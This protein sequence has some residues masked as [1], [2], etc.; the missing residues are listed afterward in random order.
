MALNP[1]RTQRVREFT[2]QILHA[3][4]DEI[5]GTGFLVSLDGRL[6]TCRHVVRDAVPGPVAV[7]TEVGVYIPKN[8]EPPLRA[9]VVGIFDESDDDIALLQLNKPRPSLTDRQVAVLG[10]PAVEEVNPFISY[11]FRRLGKYQGGRAWGKIIGD[12]DPPVDGTFLRDPIELNSEHVNYGMSGA[13]VLDTKLNLV[14]GVISEIW[15]PGASQRDRD[16][17]WAVDARVLSLEPLGLSLRAEPLPKEAS[18][19]PRAKPAGRK[20]QE[21]AA[22]FWKGAPA[23]IAEWAGRRDLL[24]RLDHDWASPDVRC[25]ALVGFGGEGKSALARQWINRLL[26]NGGVEKPDGIFWWSFSSDG[27]VDDFLEALLTHIS[28]G[29]VDAKVVTSADARAQFIGATLANGRYL[30]VL[31]GL[32][33]VQHVTG[34]SYGLVKPPALAELLS[35]LA[36]NRHDSFCLITTRVEL[37][38]IVEFTTYRCYDVNPLSEDDA[39][40]LLRLNGVAADA[41]AMRQMVKSLGGHALSLTLATTSLR[42]LDASGMDQVPSLV[43][44]DEL[45]EA[46]LEQYDKYIT[47]AERFALEALSAFRLPVA[48]EAVD[49]VLFRDWPDS[50]LADLTVG[51]RDTPLTLLARLQSYRLVTPDQASSSWTIHPLLQAHYGELMRAKPRNVKVETNYRIASF[52]LSDYLGRELIIE[53]IQDVVRLMDEK[54]DDVRLTETL[55]DLR[56]LVEA[57]YH[58]SRAEM[59]DLVWMLFRGVI[60]RGSLQYLWTRLGAYETSCSILSHLFPDGDTA[61]DPLVSEEI[62][63]TV[64]NAMAISLEHVGQLMDALPLYDRSLKRCLDEEDWGGAAITSGNLSAVYRDIG[65]LDDALDAAEKGIGFASKAGEDEFYLEARR[66][67]AVILMDLGR[68]DDAAEDYSAISVGYER[69][70]EQIS[71]ISA[72]Y[73]EFLWRERNPTARE[74]TEAVVAAYLDL[75]RRQDASDALLLLAEM[76][77]ADDKRDDASEQMARSLSIADSIGSA[78]QIAHVLAANGRWSVE[79]GNAED[80]TRYLEAAL[81]RARTASLVLIEIET[82][83]GFAWLRILEEDL[84]GAKSYARIAAQRSEATGYQWGKEEAERLEGA[85]RRIRKR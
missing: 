10:A 40:E 42:A 16:T 54:T 35:Y 45:V 78:G 52:Y 26:E 13:P 66:R 31:D 7:G 33:T 19:E 8:N 75:G 46:L 60:Q 29:K 81:E 18:P 22:Q 58:F 70:G 56:P 6:V 63:A 2:V 36:S 48:E 1:N 53:D 57:A 43:A 12:V 3:V 76:L 59:F 85:L 62:A 27:K 65:A 83:V 68:R 55:E 51:L 5:V 80:A 79:C 38:Q 17:A 41:N 15:N 74:L 82:L 47:P 84:A 11:G 72:S 32:E 23:P 69:L 67:R 30:L 71:S 61:K 64:I 37:N 50:D 28:G 73:L 14:V 39:F 24:S 20:D 44:H 25:V 77:A 34:D 49:L 21:G 4:T 9:R